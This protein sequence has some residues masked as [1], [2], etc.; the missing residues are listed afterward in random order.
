MKR[1]LL[2]VCTILLAHAVAA[3]EPADHPLVGRYPESKITHQEVSNFGQYRVLVGPDEIETVE[4]KVWMTLYQA[5]GDSSTFSVYSTYRDFLEAEGFTI[6]VSCEPGKCGGST[7]TDAYNRAPFA[8]HGNYNYSAPI[9]HGN[10][11]A[12]C[13]LSAKRESGGS[14]IYVSIAIAA[15]WYDFPQYKLDVVE[16]ASNT[17]SIVSVGTPSE[18][19][20]GEPDT[21]APTGDAGAAQS[22]APATVDT[23]F[24]SDTGSFRAQAGYAAFAFTDPDFAGGV[25]ITTEG[26]ISTATSIGFRNPHGPYAQLSFYP[27][28]NL[29]VTVDGA[30]LTRNVK[31]TVGTTAA[32]TVVEL[33]IIKTGTTVRVVGNEWPTTLSLGFGGGVTIVSLYESW[34]NGTDIRVYDVDDVFPLGYFSAELSVP[35]FSVSQLSAGFDYLF[36]PAGELDV[37]VPAGADYSREYLWS[38]LGGFV[39]RI[40]LVVEL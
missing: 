21:A 15:G 31:D 20:A 37:A 2:F 19:P 40:G 36:M 5:P 4:G 33:M 9:T 10:H 11:S 26:A 27:N 29:G 1:V 38:N 18:E 39:I 3:A 23:G 25:V 24:F 16:V 12:A 35:L 17:A 22:T 13:Y 28:Q 32:H 30:F 6:L 34:N 7:L 8:D 14:T